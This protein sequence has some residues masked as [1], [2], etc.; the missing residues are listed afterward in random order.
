M[1]L[2]VQEGD[3]VTHVAKRFVGTHAGYTRLSSLMERS[4]DLRGV[5]VQ[6][7]DGSIV[8]ASEFNLSRTDRAQY[9]EYSVSLGVNPKT[10]RPSSASAR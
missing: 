4:S 3:Y 5:R 8:I 9:D 7:P 10:R 6:L 1:A 2:H